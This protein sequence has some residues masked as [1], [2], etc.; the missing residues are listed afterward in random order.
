MHR[1]SKFIVNSS[2]F[3]NLSQRLFWSLSKAALRLVVVFYILITLAVQAARGDA[4]HVTL[5]GDPGALWAHDPSTMI[6]DGSHYYYY[7]TGQGILS[8]Y[9][10]NTTSWFEGSAVFSTQPS[11]TTTAVPGFTGYF[12]APEISY[13]NGL[14]HMYYAVSTFGSQVSAIGMATSTSLSNP[15]WTDHGSA[16]LQSHVGSAFN[17]IDPSIL[18]DN[19]GNMW[20]TFGSF[21]QGIYEVQLDPTTG[22]LKSPSNP[23]YIQLAKN[24][25]DPNDAIEASYLYHRG[26][27]YYLFVNWD[28]LN[29][30]Y[31]I[32]VG[33]STS[34]NGPFLDQSGV[35]M[36]SGGGTLFLASEGN[37]IAPG[38]IG[39][40]T[41][42]NTEY[43]SYHYL[44]GNNNNSATYGI[45]QMFWTNDAWPS[46][47]LTDSIWCGAS[48][49]NG[50][51]SSWVNWGGNA[52]ATGTDLKFGALVAGG[53]TTCQNDNYAAPQYTAL[54]F[55]S[56]AAAYT[57]T[58]SVI[59]LA[60]PIVNSSAN[61]QV[62]NLNVF[63]DTGSG[64]I[65]TG[66]QKLT[67]GGI[68]GE[69]GGSKSLAKTG[70]GELVLK[71]SNTYT[72]STTI[73]QG[74]LTLDGGD[75]ADS[76]TINVAGGAMLQVISGTPGLGNIAGLG[77][78]T[79]SGAGTVLTATS[80]SQNTLTIGAGATVIIAP[81]P[82]GP[83]GIE[84]P[85]AVPEP[86]TFVMLLM[87]AAIA[88]AMR[89]SSRHIGC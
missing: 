89:K 32:R 79:V 4:V 11:W 20:M 37:Y 30:T 63:L 28:N 54:R 12:W 61:N 39:I 59:R 78:T 43:Y 67:I 62:V 1:R 23:T 34:V 83:L 74:T 40:Y 58:G 3:L 17:T 73:N 72:G 18:K 53:F 6:Y 13:F 24:P 46:S 57:L 38:Q 31:N 35:N 19:N 25:A 29:N 33:R 85:Q 84:I 88:V 42:S 15:V 52:P 69:I 21:W 45:N 75:L 16:V 9:S 66:A 7:C 49:A 71:A 50:L 86:G 77:S 56:N 36:V 80:I 22:L 60:G 10:S 87:A 55:Q 82:G 27:Y 81:I 48:T 14:Y 68:L 2:L 70:S 76:S 65:D 8:K 5:S 44:D 41:K 26:G 51:W 47:S 64:S